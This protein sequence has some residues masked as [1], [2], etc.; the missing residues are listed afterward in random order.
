M[1][2]AN[3]GTTLAGQLGVEETLVLW[4]G[5]DEQDERTVRAA[6]A[7]AVAGGSD[8]RPLV[9]PKGGRPGP[10]R[11]AAV[12]RLGD[13]D[14]VR[15]TTG[16]RGRL[17]PIGLLFPGQG[18]QHVGMAAGLYGTEPVFTSAID[19][20]LDLMGDEAAGIRADWLGDGHGIEI[21][22]VRR[23]QPLLFAVD[24]ALGRL[25]LSWG[26]RPAAM[27]GHSAGEVVAA[28]LAGVFTLAE[29]VALVCDRVRAAVRIPAGGMLAVAASEAEL[30]PYLVGDTA[31][32]AVNASRQTMLAGSTESLRAVAAALES[33]DYT[34]RTVP[35]TTPF[36]CGAMAPAA[37]NAQEWFSAAPRPPRI[38]VYSGY[39]TDLLTAA[40]V[41]SPRFW[42]GQLTGT[43]YFG[44][45]LDRMLAGG[46]MLL[47]EVG[48]GQTLS[49][50]AR[51]HPRIRAR[52]SSVVPMLPAGPG[53]GSDWRTVLA[54]M[55]RIWT[56]G[57]DLDPR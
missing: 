23:A 25:V 55:A 41:T 42:A 37:A 27:L 30:R 51:R 4:S 32:A 24:Y 15:A 21:D 18:S 10:V 11:G 56:E 9:L 57:H 44:P 34:V 8:A 53:A 6:T 1:I 16:C 49:S 3:V 13:D 33:A 17:R 20:V 47:V 2:A 54:A 14:L 22:D 35:A 40:D 39:T 38:P 5:R 48:P 7:R 12:V 31:I 29:A 19:E 45:A 36:H 46:D 50:F 43:V 52:T 26:V 28:T